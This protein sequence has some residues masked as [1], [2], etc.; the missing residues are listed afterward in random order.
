LQYKKENDMRLNALLILAALTVSATA[1]NSYRSYLKDHISYREHPLD[2]TKMKV[3]VRFEPEKGLVKGTVSHSFTV[4]Q[5]KV[6]SV[7]FDGPGIRINKALLNNK[8]LPYTIVKTGIWVKPTTAFNWDETGVI[9]FEYEAT[10]RK[11]IYFIGWN[12]PENPVQN[13]FAVRKQIWTQGQ[14]VDN[15]YWIPMYDELNDKFITETTITFDKNYEVLSNGLLQKKTTNKDNTITWQYAMSKPHAGYLLML[16]IGKY[17]IKKT[18]SDKGIPLNLYYYPEFADR[19]E[20]TYR[21]SERM[22]DFLERETGIPYPWESYSQIMVQDFLYG[23]ME[24]TTA[25]IFGDFF[26]VDERAYIDRNY[27]GVNCHELTHQWFGDYITARDWRDTWLQESYATFYPKQF[28]KELFGEDEYNWQRRGEQNAALEASKKDVNP[29][30]HSGGGSARN[31]P[32]GSNVISMLGYVLGEEEWK[33]ALNHYLKV[34]AYAN[35]ETNDL[36]QAIQDKLGKDLSWF[37]DQWIYR[38]GEPEYTV[39]Y[40]DIMKAD[41]ER[42]T[43][44]S[45]AQTHARTEVVGLFKMPVVFEVYY[46]DGTKD[47]VTE[48]IEE[49]NEVVKVNNKGHKEIAF[50]LFDPN[51]QVLKSVTFNKSFD[52][53]EAQVQKAPFM[54]DRYDALVA[55]RET[56][57]EAKKALLLNVF[58]KETFHQM[59]AEVIN[60]LVNDEQSATTLQQV[61]TQSAP[62]PKLAALKTYNGNS[63]SWKQVFTKALQDSSYDV[64][65]ASLEKLCKQYPLEAGKFLDATKHVYGMN[66]VVNIKWHELAASNLIQPEQSTNELV[67]YASNAWEFRTRNNAFTSLKKL[68][69]CDAKLVVNLFDA[70]LSTN[71]R[72]AGPAAQLAEFLA[73]Q[74]VYKNMFVAYHKGKTWE[75]WQQEQLKKHLPFLY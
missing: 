56:P 70:V 74:T 64:V 14:G 65:L 18:K 40:N 8:N 28:T 7:F 72:L 32:K 62:S 15:R 50:V 58:A 2:I 60:Q 71:A 30:R 4:L 12:V 23:A 25:T 21:Y 38:G 55:L 3:D 63:E 31:Y 52:E 67:N 17:A 5:K 57:L 27:V 42:Y 73:Q 47:K 41:G 19:A 26:N 20:P 59:K 35:V 37:F 33:R 13:P 24:N 45:V 22:I 9:T 44:I 69:Y 61:F 48:W 39:G 46:A 54:L 34:H 16:G 43:E 75:P 1:Q 29:I 36:Q 53:L 68:G 49:A 6:D 51:S 10:P 11:G 66:N